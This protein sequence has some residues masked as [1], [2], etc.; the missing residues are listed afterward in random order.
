MTRK[1]EFSSG[2][3]ESEPKEMQSDSGSDFGDYGVESEYLPA[4]P[5][6]RI[7][8]QQTAETPTSSKHVSKTDAF[9]TNASEKG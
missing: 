6:P 2:H 9:D 1:L 7:L 5:S 3:Q 8:Y 4:F